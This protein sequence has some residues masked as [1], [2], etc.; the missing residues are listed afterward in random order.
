MVA[1]KRFIYQLIDPYYLS[2]FS[3]SGAT[4]AKT[5][6]VGPFSSHRR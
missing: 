5:F 4:Y 6:H 3:L 2:D 1:P